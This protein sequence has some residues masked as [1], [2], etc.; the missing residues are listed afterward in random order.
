MS[1]R[2][3][4]YTIQNI[5]ITKAKSTI[6][7]SLEIILYVFNIYEIIHKKDTA[8]PFHIYALPAK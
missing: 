4:E 6:L 3:R 7:V 8:I 1:L 5:Y 2:L